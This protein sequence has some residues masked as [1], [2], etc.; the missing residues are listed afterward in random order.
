M[1]KLPSGKK[2]YTYCKT[3]RPFL[4]LSSFKKQISLYLRANGKCDDTYIQAH[5]SGYNFSPSSLRF[6][7][8]LFLSYN[9]SISTVFL[10][11]DLCN[12]LQ[13]C[14]LHLHLETLSFKTLLFRIV[15]QY[16]LYM[17]V[18]HIKRKFVGVIL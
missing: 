5:M 10:A 9:C 8:N 1:E 13:N 2:S 15:K 17:L 4:A 18:I 14:G 11:Q 12:K 6:S 16:L 3:D 7:A